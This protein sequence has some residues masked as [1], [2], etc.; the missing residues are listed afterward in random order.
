MSPPRPLLGLDADAALRVA[1]VLSSLAVRDHKSVVCSLHYPSPE[2]LYQSNWHNILFMSEGKVIYNGKIT[3]LADYITRLNI[4]SFLAVDTAPC[5]VEFTLDILGKDPSASGIL[6]AAWL[7]RGNKTRWLDTSPD[8]VIPGGGE[9]LIG[10]EHSERKECSLDTEGYA[11][12]RVLYEIAIV[13]LRHFMY[14]VHAREGGYRTVIGRYILAGVLFGVT[15]QNTGRDMQD[16]RS[17]FE[18][19]EANFFDASYN[20]MSIEFCMCCFIVVSCC[21]SIPEMYH[22]REYYGRE[23]VSGCWGSCLYGASSILCVCCV[24][25]VGVVF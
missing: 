16:Q 13:S 10:S 7:R 2:I 17:V 22:M 23:T 25:L 9:A 6:S 12:H 5:A 24:L 20:M 4:L 18:F 8:V 11:T 19:K 21:L 15:F 1:N 3:A 14:K